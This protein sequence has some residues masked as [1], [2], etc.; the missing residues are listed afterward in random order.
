MKY[1]HILLLSLIFSLPSPIL[2]QDL[3]DEKKGLIDELLLLTGAADLGQIFS[4]IYIAEMTNFLRQAQPDADPRIFTILENEV[5]SVI[6]DEVGNKQIINELSY[7]IYHKYLTSEDISELIVFYQ[8]DLGIKTLSVMP[9]IS[10]EAT[11]AGQ[12]WGRSLG[13]QIQ[14]RIMMRFQEEGI[15]IQ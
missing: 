10:R 15:E 4:R 12:E 13:P 6:S 3:T 1:C 5:N 14:Q 8:S 2:A 11:L 7:P 9:D